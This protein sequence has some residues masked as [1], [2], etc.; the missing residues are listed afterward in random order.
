MQRRVLIAAAAATCSQRALALYDPEPSQILETA[1]GSWTG[2][3]TYREWSDPEKLVTIA[4]K[5]FVA[6]SAPEELRLFYVFADG[7]GK[8]VYSYERMAFDFKARSLVWVSGVTKP[9]TTLHTITSTATG[10]VGE[11][12]LFERAIE[13][14]VDKYALAFGKTSLSLSKTEVSTAGAQTLRN[15]YEF[16]RGEA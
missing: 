15:K 3:L 1:A 11:Q 14:R 12:V 8:V 2:T 9:E 4:C 6:L 10:A 7:P 5:L 13:G 16:R